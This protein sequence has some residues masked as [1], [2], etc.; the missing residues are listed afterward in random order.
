MS[1]IPAPVRPGPVTRVTLRQARR[2]TIQLTER[3]A[4]RAIEPIEAFAHSPRLMLGYGMLEL[5]SERAHSVELRLKELA[6]LKAA[7]MV[8][9]EYCVDIGSSIARKSGL[10]DE[11]L[12]AL[13]S[14]RDSG[15]FSELEM[16]VL[17]YVVAMSRTPVEVS[18]EL[19]AALG[20]HLDQEQLVELTSMVALENFRA[21]FNSALDIGAAGFSEGMVCARPEARAGEPV[22]A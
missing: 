19:F 9:C 6:V 16:L 11:Q 3:D 12:L 1:R 7:T 13:P 18:D 8:G 15:V 14:Y 4:E 22:G 5:A 21:R 2:K 20:E 10:S 17:D